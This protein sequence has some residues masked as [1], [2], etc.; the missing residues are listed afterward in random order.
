[1]TEP[2]A[3]STERRTASPIVAETGPVGDE[4]GRAPRIAILGARGIPARYG[5]FETFVE[6][7]APRLVRRGVDVTVFCEAE[8]GPQPAEYEG[9]KLVHVPARAPGPARS[10]AYDV[11]CLWRARRG[12]DVVYMLGYGTS[13]ACC[14]PRL[15]GTQVWINMDGL[16]WRRSKW[17]APARLWLKTMEG[18]APRSASRVI[19]DNAALAEEIRGRRRVR[20]SSVLEY[21]APV[22]RERTDP[23]RLSE[24]GVSPGEYYLVVCR[25]EPE[26]H[27]LEI[28]QAFTQAGLERPLIVVANKELGTSYARATLALDSRHVRFVGTVYD[29][30]LLLPLRQHCRAYLHGHS[31][32]GTNPSLLEAMGCGNLVVA[33]DNPYNRE[34]LGNAG[35]YFGGVPS[36]GLRLRESEALDETE[37][38]NKRRAA[39]ERIE[40]RYTWELI[41]DRYY[42]LILAATGAPALT[43]ARSSSD[44]RPTPSGRSH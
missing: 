24:L 5:G 42:A 41:A 28:A 16:E 12:F 31:V 27:V 35:L 37:L 39:L 14:L 11:S 13:F 6:E 10:I 23:S 15:H 19:F 3:L 32:G 44:R 17:S 40:E 21:G 36:L 34:T 1:M 2:P 20:C 33:H 43:C 30:E 8:H 29:Q 18:L 4:P 38:A 25:F 26:N 9:V 22:L 7:L